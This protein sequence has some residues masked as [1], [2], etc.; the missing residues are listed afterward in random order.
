M[1]ELLFHRGRGYSHPAEKITVVKVTEVETRPD[2]TVI[3]TEDWKSL[4]A[5]VHDLAVVLHGPDRV[6]VG[7]R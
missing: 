6:A 5:R 3:R 1:A 4:I 2:G 7:K